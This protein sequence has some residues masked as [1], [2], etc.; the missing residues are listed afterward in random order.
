MSRRLRYC[1]LGHLKEGRGVI[2]R[3]ALQ[4][5]NGK[6]YINRRCR[7]CHLA[8]VKRSK[9]KRRRRLSG[10]LILRDR[11]RAEDDGYIYLN[12]SST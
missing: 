4:A 8:A 2:L 11:L 3:V 6:P 1:Y 7:V 10:E 5:Y 9:E 12:N